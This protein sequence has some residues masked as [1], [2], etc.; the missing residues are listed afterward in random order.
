MTA[1]TPWGSYR[2][3]QPQRFMAG[4]SGAE[5]YALVGNLSQNGAMSVGTIE[6]L[7]VTMK[8][9]AGPGG[10]VVVPT[11]RI[12]LP[13]WTEDTMPEVCLHPLALPHLFVTEQIARGDVLGLLGPADTVVQVQSTLV[14][15]AHGDT[16]MLRD[17]FGTMLGRS[18][19]RITL[20]TN[21]DLGVRRARS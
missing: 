8:T 19:F 16:Q 13:R 10:F 3:P 4:L 9:K 2:T 7:R 12:T 6:G 18:R 14:D 5:V 20:Q 11:Y 1:L 21:F 15:R 17:Y